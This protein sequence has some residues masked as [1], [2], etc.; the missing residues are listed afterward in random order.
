MK[1]KLD[2]NVTTEME[3]KIFQIM[4]QDCTKNADIRKRAQL[5]AVSNAA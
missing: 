5:K 4:L 3:R 2:K 1:P